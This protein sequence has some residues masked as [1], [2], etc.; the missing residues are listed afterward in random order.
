MLI[1]TGGHIE[2]V[3]YVPLSVIFSR[4]AVCSV[5]FNCWSS[6]YIMYIVTVR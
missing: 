3:I 4:D 6:T 1:G 5:T 2:L